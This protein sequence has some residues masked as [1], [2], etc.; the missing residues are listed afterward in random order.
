MQAGGL[1]RQA[2]RPLHEW[3]P[4]EADDPVGL[5]FLARTLRLAPDAVLA[6]FGWRKDSFIRRFIRTAFP[7]WF[8]EGNVGFGRQVLHQWRNFRPKQVV[9][10]DRNP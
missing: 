6:D 10:R 9:F 1:E 5:F 2:S 7:D 8:G 4:F 3:R